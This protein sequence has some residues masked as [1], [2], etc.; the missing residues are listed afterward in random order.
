MW[1]AIGGAFSILSNPVLLQNNVFIGNQAANSGGALYLDNI[2]NLQIEHLATLI[3]NSF[4]N[5]RA[6]NSAGGAIYS[7]IAKPLIFNSIFWNDNAN[8]GQE[9]FVTY[10]N[11]T[12]EIAYSNINLRLY[13]GGYIIDGFGNINE[14]PLFKDLEWLTISENSPCVNTGTEEYICHCG[15][16]T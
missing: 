3:N 16:L 15:N 8:N 14:D 9:I 13:S 11:D 10:P 4:Y 7:Y 6:T 12:V 1:P 2:L 5:N